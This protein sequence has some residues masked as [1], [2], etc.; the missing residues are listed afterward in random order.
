MFQLAGLYGK[1]LLARPSFMEYR[2][3]RSYDGMHDYVYAQPGLS[4]IKP[5]TDQ[6]SRAGACNERAQYTYRA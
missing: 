2:L 5:P 3:E 4:I 6:A 1:P